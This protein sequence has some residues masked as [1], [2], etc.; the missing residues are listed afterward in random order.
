MNKRSS[1]A[2][3]KPTKRDFRFKHHFSNKL[4]VS[5]AF[6]ENIFDAAIKDFQNGKITLDQFT[7]IQERLQNASSMISNE[8]KNIYSERKRT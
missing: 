7:A 1:D 5:A 3:K 8:L 2:F 4:F 6:C